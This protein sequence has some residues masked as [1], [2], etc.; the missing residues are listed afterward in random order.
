MGW[1]SDKL[2]GKRKRL[3]T[4]KINKM[5]E[6]TQSLVSE[7]LG[8]S[9]QLMDPESAINMQMRNL[10]AQRASETGAQVGMQM[11]RMG[12]MRGM[13]PAQAMMQA[14][15]AQTQAMGGVNQQWQQGL[16]NQF[17]QGVG[18]M[19][20]MTQMQQGLNE[21]QVQG[22]LSAIN[23]SNARRSQNMGMGMSLVGGLMGNIGNFGGGD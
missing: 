9:R 2:Y 1:L 14:R 5:M 3:D 18:L 8:L 12:A 19:G 7:Q 20:N 6:P 22:Y 17:G 21:N 11:Q 13:S 10:M 16:Q 15:M 23:A 4:T